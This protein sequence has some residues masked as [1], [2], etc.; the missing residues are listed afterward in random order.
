MKLS[1]RAF[2]VKKLT[3]TGRITNGDFLAQFQHF[4][5]R[6]R[7]TDAWMRGYW[8]QMGFSIHHFFG[9]SWEKNG[10]E[11]KQICNGGP[12]A[13]AGACRAPTLETSEVRV[14]PVAPIQGAG[15][16]AG[17]PGGVPSA[18]H[19]PAPHISNRHQNQLPL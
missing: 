7:V 1:Q 13:T 11:L 4:T 16:H 2:A 12:A 9:E 15:A 14:L 18:F 19:P 6:N 17:E 8:Y 10:W 3:E 5:G